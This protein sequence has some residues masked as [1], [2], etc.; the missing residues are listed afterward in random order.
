MKADGIVNFGTDLDNPSFAESLE[1]LAC[2]A[3]RSSEPRNS[4]P[5]LSEAFAY[6]GP[7]LVEVMTVRHE[8]SIP[9]RHAQQ[10]NG[11][12]LWATRSSSTATATRYSSRPNQ[13]PPAGARMNPA[14]SAG[15]LG[16]RILRK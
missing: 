8:L 14:H 13:P 1:P 5:R 16:R 3:S 11:F 6:D 4:T 9:P 10:A 15:I 2:T 7:A 12:T